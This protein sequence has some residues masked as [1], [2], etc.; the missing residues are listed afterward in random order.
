MPLSIC[1]NSIPGEGEGRILMTP[2]F[3]LLLHR[4]MDVDDLPAIRPLRQEPIRVSTQDIVVTNVRLA[5]FLEAIRERFAFERDGI[6][7]W[8]REMDNVCPPGEGLCPQPEDAVC[9]RHKAIVPERIIDAVV[10]PVAGDDQIRFELLQNAIEP[11]MQIG[12]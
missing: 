6:E 10:H 11:L 8:R 1:M 12:P 2:L 9:E 5:I 4:A 7:Y 3:E